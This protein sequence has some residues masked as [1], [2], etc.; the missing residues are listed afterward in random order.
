VLIA[1]E[2]INGCI[3]VAVKDRGAGIPD[4]FRDLIFQKFAQ[5][6]S[7]TTR[8]KG[9]TGL[10]LSIAKAIIERMDGSIW[11]DSKPDVLTVFYV[12]L[13]EWVGAEYSAGAPAGLKGENHGGQTDTHLV[14]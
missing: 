5:A 2:R 9:G 14:R 6:D 4:E 8:N 13:P 12:E 3:R 10:G 7:S 1:V 11:F